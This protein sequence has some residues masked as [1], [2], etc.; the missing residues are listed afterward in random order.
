MNQ[1]FAYL[2]S[3]GGYFDFPADAT[4]DL[5]AA[6]SALAADEFIFDDQTHHVNP[7]GPWRARDQ[8]CQRILVWFPQGGCGLEDP[9][10]C[11]SA[12]HYIKELF[13]DSDTSMAVLSHPPAPADGNPLTTEDAAATRALVAAVDGSPRLLIQGLVMPGLPLA[14][15]QLDEMERMAGAFKVR[16]WKTYTNWGIDGGGWWLD[17][18]AVGIPFIETARRLGVKVIAVHK[19]LPFSGYDPVYSTCRDVGSAARMFP[20]VNFIVYHA[21]YDGAITEGPYD[22]ARARRGVNNLIKSLRDHGVPPNANVYADL[23]ATWRIVMR[24]PTEA[25]HTV[26]KL[27]KYLGEDRVLWGTDS[28]WFGSPQDQIQAFRSFQIAESVQEQHGYPELTAGIKR[29]VFGLNALG[30]FGV[31][32][33]E[34]VR[35]ADADRIGRLRAAYLH[36]ARPSFVSYGPR[37]AGEFQALERL[38]AGLP[39]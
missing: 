14:Q 36:Q 18:P 32:P 5:D 6:A 4:L 2:G 8:M 39:G 17:D 3:K 30:A 28:I 27:L 29:K 19:G 9:V 33:E 13:L 35:K 12:R 21:G 34:V 20:D 10:D 1:A 23:G 26:G 11:F 7:V 31:R 15:S 24:S 22:P 37:N 16:S 38:N 25:A